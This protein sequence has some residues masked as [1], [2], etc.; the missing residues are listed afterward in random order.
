MNKNP[1]LI[2]PIILNTQNGKNAEEGSKGS[3]ADLYRSQKYGIICSY[4]LGVVLAL[5]RQSKLPALKMGSVFYI[6]LIRGVPLISLLFM[7]SVL[8]PLFL[9]EGVVIDKLLRAQ[10]AI[11]FFSAAYMAEVV[12]G[13]LQSIPIGQYEAARALGLNYFQTMK[14]I[15]LHKMLHNS[16]FCL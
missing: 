6:E 16:K 14:N 12:R 10:M 9:P 3:D 8:F 13:G 1:A 15:I 5:C 2:N 11:I 4:P 7:S